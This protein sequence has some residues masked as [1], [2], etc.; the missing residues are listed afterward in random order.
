MNRVPDTLPVPPALRCVW[1]R[2]LLRAPGCADDTTTTVLWLQAA[3]WHADI[4]IPAGRPDFSGV[5]S[6]SDCSDA[7]LA[8]LATQRGFAGVTTVD[9]RT[10]QTNWLR[11]VDFQPPSALPDAGYMELSHDML[12]ETGV[13]ADYIEH[14]HRVPLTDNGYAVLRRVD[15]AEPTLLMTAGPM[16]MQVRS[17][18]VDFG[19][20]GWASG[21]P[22][23]RQLDFDIS[24]GVRNA[25]GWQVQHSTLPWL[26]GQQRDV[27]LTEL[28]GGRICLTIDRVPSQW[29]VLEW[30]PPRVRG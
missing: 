5:Q 10:Q 23:R 26:E 16:V 14:W 3:R 2:S 4:R 25:R 27:D 6:L 1:R 19:A 8:W 20:Q 29:E 22:L 28:G 7:Q 21:E 30:T 13:H 9:L 18:S 11:V 24:C 15:A 17:R 12:I